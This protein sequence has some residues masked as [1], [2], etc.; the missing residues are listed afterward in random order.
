MHQS[1]FG[2]EK[3]ELKSGPEPEFYHPYFKKGSKEVK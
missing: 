1:G 3:A 2:T